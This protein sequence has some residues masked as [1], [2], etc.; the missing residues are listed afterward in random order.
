M[1][2]L[3]KALTLG[4]FL[5]F[6]GALVRSAIIEGG[7]VIEGV[8]QN[9]LADVYGAAALGTGAILA[10]VTDT[11]SQQVITTG[12]NPLDRGRR[13]TATAGGTGGDIGAVQVVITGTNAEDKVIT[14]TLPAFT[15][16]TPGI[17][18][19]VKAFKTVTQVDLPAHDGTAATTAIGFGDVIGIGHRLARN[20][21]ISAFLGSTIEGTAP[22]IVFDATDLEKN[23]VDLNSALN[24]TP[25]IIELVQT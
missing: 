1:S 14:E 10:A 25:V 19:G 21:V 11:G 6:V 3:I 7:V 20:T 15:V 8:R 22:A 17:V 5:A 24:D 16:D 12:I 2:K 18:A 4:M 9:V 23:T 13:I